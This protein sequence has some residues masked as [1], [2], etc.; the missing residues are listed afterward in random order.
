MMVVQEACF[1]LVDRFLQRSFK[2]QLYQIWNSLFCVQ[3]CAK[4]RRH[5]QH[6]DFINKWSIK[7]SGVL[8]IEQILQ[9]GVCQQNII[10]WMNKISH[11]WNSDALYLF[12]KGLF[13]NSAL[14]MTHYGLTG[15]PLCSVSSWSFV[16]ALNSWTPNCRKSQILRLPTVV[17]CPDLR[18]K[19]KNEQNVLVLLLSFYLLIWPCLFIFWSVRFSI[20][21]V[22]N[23][24]IFISILTKIAN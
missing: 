17:R 7:P 22:W 4:N 11:P 24:F 13:Y 19:Q 18:R 3:I 12:I 23:F 8:R 16:S 6:R 15:L 10:F 9:F 1:Y 14:Y 5:A 21:F 20:K 2:P